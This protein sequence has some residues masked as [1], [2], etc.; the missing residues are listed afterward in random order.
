[1]ASRRDFLFGLGALGVAA[2]SKTEKPS[3]SAAL[4]R[5]AVPAAAR[6]P[7]PAAQR[8]DIQVL[9]WDFD[10][11]VGNMTR[12]AI[13]VPSWGA[14]DA[15]YPVLVALH[16]RGEAVKPPALGALG[17]PNDYQ[18]VRAMNRLRAPPL[19]DADYEGL[20]DPERMAKL[21]ASLQE[22][23]FRGLIVACP[24]VPDVMYG[25]GPSVAEVGDFI[26]RVLLPRVRK[27]TPARDGPES[28]GIDG[29]SMGGMLALRVGLSNPTA[30]GAV[31]TLQAAIREEE[32]AE[33]TALAKAA[34][35][36]RPK[37]PLRLLTSHD[38]YFRMAIRRLSESLRA[39]GIDHELADVPGPHDYIF[40]RGPGSI[41]MLAW[42][43]RL[44][45]H[46]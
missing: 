39:A 25:E 9:E 46:G 29:V 10:G 35:A 31:G 17:W 33:L 4:P 36:A 16:G 12:A 32:A 41:E 15:R 11:S 20:S 2:C 7:L 34:R 43:D 37:L 22:K 6:E 24:H 30:F 38:D 13:V 1:M 26:T 21:N 42:H 18:L 44:L 19:T 40:N 8:R 27:E 28:T 45:A 23:P 5:I 14:P 3:P